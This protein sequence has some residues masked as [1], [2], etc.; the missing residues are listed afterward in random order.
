[1]LGQNGKG[2]ACG[3]SNHQRSH[4]EIVER[5][6]RTPRPFDR[7]FKRNSQ[8]VCEHSPDAVR[9]VGREESLPACW[10]VLYR[11]ARISDAN[12]RRID[13]AGK[14]TSALTADA[15]C[16]FF[17]EP[18]TQ[19]L[20]PTEP[21][22]R[23]RTLA[24]IKV[25]ASLDLT[26]AA[27]LRFLLQKELQGKGAAIEFSLSKR[28]WRAQMDAPIS[29]RLR[30][31]LVARAQ[32]ACGL[33]E[34]RYKALDRVAYQHD[35]RR[36]ERRYPLSPTDPESIENPSH[37]FT[38]DNKRSDRTRFFAEI[39]SKNILTPFSPSSLFVGLGE[40]A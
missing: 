17:R 2:C 32:S 11:L 1:V 5:R 18:T 40:L 35:F 31:L 38:I 3:R 34:N 19:V 25:P 36:R 30:T 22:P 37:P 26:A 4:R 28:E 13:D 6:V 12:F 33:T 21:R 10:T 23:Q 24:I 15:M 39:H 14:I 29:D 20:A 8:Q 7:N 16:E 9:F 27:N